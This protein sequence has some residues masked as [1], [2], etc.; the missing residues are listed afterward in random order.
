MRQRGGCRIRPGHYHGG[1]RFLA[2][3]KGEGKT[4]QSK[5]LHKFRLLNHLVDIFAISTEGK[6]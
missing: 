5:K 6:P 2:A 1:R 3:A 4:L